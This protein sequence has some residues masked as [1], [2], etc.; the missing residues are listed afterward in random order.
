MEEGQAEP[1]RRGR[2]ASSGVR[3]S[4]ARE[5]VEGRLVAALSRA[6]V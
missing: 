1:A 3:A 4:I 6:L 5:E 2:E